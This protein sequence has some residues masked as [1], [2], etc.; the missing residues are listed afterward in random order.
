MLLGLFLALVALFCSVA[1][2]NWRYGLFLSYVIGLLQ[3]PVRKMIEGTPRYLMLCFVPVYLASLVGLSRTPRALTRVYREAPHLRRGLLAL[4]VVTLF[5]AFLTLGSYGL[6]AT[7]LVFLG[8]VS[9]FG[10]VPALSL[11]F[12]LTRQISYLRRVLAVVALLSALFSLGGILEYL[13][14]K[15]TILGTLEH[16]N[17]IHHFGRGKQVRML[18]G[19]FRSPESLGWHGALVTML[20]FTLLLTARNRVTAAVWLVPGAWGIVC[21]LISGRRKML[22]MVLVFVGVMVVQFL[23]QRRRSNAVI[24]LGCAVVLVLILAQYYVG[25]L[26]GASSYVELGETLFAHDAS[27][28]FGVSGYETISDTIRQQGF[29]GYGLGTVS[30]GMQYLGVN[31]PKT[32]QEGGFGKIVGELGIPGLL[33]CAYV[34]LALLLECLWSIRGCARSAELG[35]MANCLFAILLANAACFL[36]AHQLYGDPFVLYL[37]GIF[38]GILLSLQRFT[39]EQ[40]HLLVQ[41][42]P[43]TSARVLQKV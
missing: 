36:V 41:P 37:L 11:G 2:F 35:I 30:Q 5:G 28:R 22:F 14:Y 21:A 15:W 8:M 12:N 10:G 24:V 25:Q 17:W 33:V 18:C 4:F 43:S 39:Q 16:K 1:V 29:L 32:W 38:V 34:G 20:A 6:A 13:D 19:F 7:S 9:Y 23:R 3:D 26:D 40:H 27:D 42:S 31:R